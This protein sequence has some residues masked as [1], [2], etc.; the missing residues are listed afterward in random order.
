MEGRPGGS[1]V[2]RLPLAQGLILESGDQVPHWVPGMEPASPSAY[3][4]LLRVPCIYP[5]IQS[6]D[7]QPYEVGSII[8]SILQRKKWIH[9]KIKGT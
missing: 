5:L 4:E 7:R 8:V 3:L 9:R 1:V 2:T 6:Y